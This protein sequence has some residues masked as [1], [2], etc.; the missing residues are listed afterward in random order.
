LARKCSVV[1]SGCAVDFRSMLH[2]KQVRKMRCGVYFGIGAKKMCD[3]RLPQRCRWDLRSSV[4]LRS[5][6]L[7]FLTNVSGQH[8]CIYLL[9]IMWPTV[10][11]ERPVRNYPEKCQ[12]FLHN[13]IFLYAIYEEC[14]ESKD[15]KVLNM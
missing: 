7:Y 12:T 5:V 11:Y 1:S 15:T 2:V 10:C 3:F 6:E 13:N 14:T 8:S 9:F 4:L